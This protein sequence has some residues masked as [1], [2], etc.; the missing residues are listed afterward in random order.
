MRFLIIDTYYNVFLERFYAENPNWG[1]QA[2]EAKWR[3][4][5]DQYFGTA[6]FY[7]TNL[8]R[9]GHEATEIVANCRPLQLQWAAE[10]GL[11]LRHKIQTGYYP[12]LRSSLPRLGK[13]WFYPV[14][15]AQ[16]KWHRPDVI[17][18]QDPA[19]TD[20]NFVREIRPYVRA[21]SAQIAS[22]I[23]AKA[24][25]S[26]YDLMLSSLPNFVDS[27]RQ[28]G[29]RSAQLNAGFEPRVLDCLKQVSAFDVVFVGGLSSSHRSR[30]QF[31]ENVAAKTRMDWW[32]YGL[33]NLN[34]DSPLRKAFRGPAWALAMYEKLLS[35][36]I[37]L[38]HHIDVAEEY[39][40]N[41]RLYEATG[42]GS[43]LVTDAKRNLPALFELGKEAAAYGDSAECVE[44]IE[45]YLS[46]E[47]Q[48]AS[49]AYSGQQGTLR[50]HSYLTRMK[51]F[52]E[53]IKPLL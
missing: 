2:Y 11:V 26:P 8:Q 39:A 36:R 29:M 17:H 45:Y 19:N 20:P 47:E 37:T 15:L 10:R 24:D 5:M 48:R 23:P 46:H 42:V 28:Q 4:L 51:E 27:F 7:S 53:L 21:I 43:L 32:G 38:N 40:N 44:L 50:Q 52:L 35:A 22:P 18:F 33:E 3:Y 1:Q 31:L 34:A 49:T 16:I 13:D 6:D 25:L 12:R 30:I 9:L 41:M 14:L